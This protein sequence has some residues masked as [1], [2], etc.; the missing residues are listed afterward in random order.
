M[1]RVEIRD[2]RDDSTSLVV[3]DAGVVK[4]VGGAEEGFGGA[5]VDGGFM[6]EG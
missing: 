6:K 4:V 1:I 2:P 3:V 5:V